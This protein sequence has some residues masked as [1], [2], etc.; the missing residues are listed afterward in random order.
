MGARAFMGQARGPQAQVDLV[1]IACATGPDTLD[2]VDASTGVVLYRNQP[3]RI[4]PNPECQKFGYTY[5][6]EA[7]A[8][9]QVPPAQPTLQTQPAPESIKWL[10]PTPGSVY[11]P[12]LSSYP[13]VSS[14]YSVAQGTPFNTPPSVVNVATQPAAPAPTPAPMAPMPVPAPADGPSVTTI[15]S[16]AAGVLALGAGAYFLIF[17]K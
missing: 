5:G 4:D 15:V 14:T 1:P 2:V 12:F 13:P 6:S 3:G 9:A 7:A 8:P 11:K 16:I 10:G 17:G